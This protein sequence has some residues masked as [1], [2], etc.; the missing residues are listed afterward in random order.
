MKK[1]L[2]ILSLCFSILSVSASV[3]EASKFAGEQYAVQ[4]GNENV[5]I[6]VKKEHTIEYKQKIGEQMV[7]AITY[8]WGDMKAKKCKKV[9]VTYICL[10]DETSKPFWSYIVPNK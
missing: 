3:T 7:P 1:L 4:T 6:N 8:G 10:L 2:L 9:R 5:R